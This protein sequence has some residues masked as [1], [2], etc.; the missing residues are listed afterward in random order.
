MHLE[1]LSKQKTQQ[2]VYV[3]VGCIFFLT[4]ITLMAGLWTYSVTKM[5]SNVTTQIQQ[6]KEKFEKN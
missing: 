4:I 5:T 3:I 2:R 6:I 1:A